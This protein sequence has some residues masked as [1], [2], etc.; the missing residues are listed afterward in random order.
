MA[1]QAAVFRRMLGW[2]RYFAIWIVAFLTEFFSR[3]F[4]HSLE[5]GMGIICGQF[6]GRFRG[7]IPQE[8]EQ[9]SAGSQKHYVVD[10][11][12]ALVIFHCYPPIPKIVLK[13]FQ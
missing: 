1:E 11:S 2:Q 3:L 10:H 8:K 12:F 7:R 5:T 13:D 6:F 4:A 9:A